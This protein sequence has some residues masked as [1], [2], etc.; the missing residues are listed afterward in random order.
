M[1]V[2]NG[3][4]KYF[5]RENLDWKEFLKLNGVC[6]SEFLPYAKEFG[7]LWEEQYGKRR[8]DFDKAI[9]R[10]INGKKRIKTVET[11][12]E[13]TREKAIKIQVGSIFRIPQKEFRY[14][15]K[16]IFLKGLFHTKKGQCVTYAGFVVALARY[17]KIPAMIFDLKQDLS[18]E[19]EMSEREGHL[20][21]I[22]DVGRELLIDPLNEFFESDYEGSILGDRAYCAVLWANWASVLARQGKTAESLKALDE[23]LAID[24]R[25]ISALINRAAA[26]LDNKQIEAAEREYDYLHKKYPKNALILL[27]RA[28][29]HFKKKE[30]DKTLECVEK[31]KETKEELTQAFMMEGFV[32][33]KQKEYGRALDSFEEADRHSRIDDYKLRVTISILEGICFTDKGDYKEAID[34][35]KFNLLIEKGVIE[36]DLIDNSFARNYVILRFGLARLYAL[37]G[38]KKECLGYLKKA[39]SKPDSKTTLEDI[40][41][42]EDF[43]FD[44]VRNDPNFKKILDRLS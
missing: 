12:D 29:C 5:A 37:Q 9:F 23:A 7:K 6:I 19:E 4:V 18:D 26:L 22:V 10:Y 34:C 24:P 35:F 38:K 33:Y 21:A 20:C 42:R 39:A 3:H 14:D 44:S 13:V 32:Y 30:Y 28:D 16:H 1:K 27:G 2:L 41:I 43:A 40:D 25:N 15:E 31:I 36:G 11:G 8:E 17:H